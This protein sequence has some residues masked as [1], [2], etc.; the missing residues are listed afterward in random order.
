MKIQ[1]IRTLIA[2]SLSFILFILAKLLEANK[3]TAR[4]CFFF[5]ILCGMLS[6]GGATDQ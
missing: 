4:I 3:D 2:G 1:S 6:L 5:F